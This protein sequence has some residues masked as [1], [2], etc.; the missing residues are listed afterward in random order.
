MPRRTCLP[1]EFQ[2]KRRHILAIVAALVLCGALFYLYAGHRTPAGQPPLAE[3]IPQNFTTIETAFNAAQDDVRV[4][5]LLSP[6]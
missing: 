1:G 5:L 6:T 4:V 3:L 2:M